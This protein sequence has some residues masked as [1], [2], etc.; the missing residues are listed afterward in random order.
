MAG[1][2]VDIERANHGF[3]LE[4]GS[5]HFLHFRVPRAVILL[6]I[7][8][9]VPEAESQDSIVIFVGDENCLIYEAFLFLVPI[10]KV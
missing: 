10:L 6:S 5:K 1:R 3:G 7:L 9:G 4:Q 2:G 8:F